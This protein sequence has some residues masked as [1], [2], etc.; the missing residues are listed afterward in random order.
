MSKKGGKKDK[1]KKF[2]RILDYLEVNHPSMYEL[3][4]DLAC[5]GN[6][7]P[8]RGGSITFLNP[9]KEYIK[10]IRKVAD[11][12]QPEKATDMIDSLILLDLFEK[13]AD[14]AAKKDEI[15]T[16]LGTKL[17]VKS[18][19]ASKVIIEDGEITLDK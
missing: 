13:P 4:D 15:S 7:T 3:I 16:L 2:P 6:L 18:V 1:L 12:D 11:S 9:D 14:F 17:I 5:Q 10:E 19:S 8:H